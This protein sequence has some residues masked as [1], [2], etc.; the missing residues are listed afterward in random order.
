MSENI[1]R[2]RYSPWYRGTCD[3]C[4]KVAPVTD[5]IVE[6]MCNQGRTLTPVRIPSLCKDCLTDDQ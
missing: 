2:P 1:P 4:G 6:E 5:T 3:D